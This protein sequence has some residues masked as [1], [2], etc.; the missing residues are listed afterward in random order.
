M[1]LREFKERKSV[2]LR[3]CTLF[4]RLQIERT[5]NFRVGVFREKWNGTTRFLLS[6]TT[7]GRAWVSHYLTVNEL[8]KIKWRVDKFL[9]DGQIDVK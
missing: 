6:V 9:R 8:R 1:K 7:D 4:R 3:P 5:S 2:R